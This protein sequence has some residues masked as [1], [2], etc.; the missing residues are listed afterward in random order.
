LP[1]QASFPW[2]SSPSQAAPRLGFYHSQFLCSN[3]LAEREGGDEHFARCCTR[4]FVDVS[5][6]VG[7]KTKLHPNQFFG[8]LSCYGAI[9]RAVTR[10]LL[11]KRIPQTAKTPREAGLH[12]GRGR[13]ICFLAVPNCPQLGPSVKR[14]QLFSVVVVLCLFL[15]P[16]GGLLKPKRRT[17]AKKQLTFDVAALPCL[18]SLAPRLCSPSGS[19]QGARRRRSS[20][21]GCRRRPRRGCGTARPALTGRAARK[22]SPSEPWGTQLCR[23]FTPCCSRKCFDSLTRPAN[24]LDM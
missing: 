23:C 1:R 3:I 9:R 10:D 17:Y 4:G 5:P 18:D 11:E 21:R 8:S 2:Q 24:R 19:G 14:K 7:C 15:A 12:S 13:E 6:T 16:S 22:G 20:F